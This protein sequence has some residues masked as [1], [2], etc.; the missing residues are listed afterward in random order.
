MRLI[1]P[2]RLKQNEAF[3][4]RLADRQLDEFIAEGRC[5]FI[6]AYSQPFAMLA[7]ADLLGVPESD[8]RRSARASGCARA[9]VKVGAE[10][11]PQEINALG[12]LDEWFASYIEDRR[13]EPRTDVLTDLAQAKY[14][15]GSTPDVTAVVRIATFL[16]AAG[17]ETTARL[18]A[19]ALEYLVEYPRTPRRAARTHRKDPELHRRD[20]AHGEPGEGRL[21]ARA[22]ERNRRRGRHRSG[23]TR[24]AA[25]R[26]GQPRSSSLRVARPSSAP[27]GRT[28]RNTSRSGAV[29]TRVRAG[30]WRASKA[31]SASSASCTG[32]AT[33]GCRKNTTAPPATGGW[34]GS[35]RGCCAA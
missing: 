14:P 8:H 25:Q 28:P 16:F 4:W 26:R 35:R 11:A 9:R 3:M 5:E 1:T 19:T 24:H 29:P 12:L 10:D 20:A 2:K 30:R 18:L 33:S 7:V 13:R 27:I 32:R 6:S 23:R 31:A 22:P 21:P 34:S 17:Q 15:D